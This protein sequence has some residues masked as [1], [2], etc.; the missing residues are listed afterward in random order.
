LEPLRA[1]EIKEENE[2]INKE[3]R[4]EEERERKNRTQLQP[5]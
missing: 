1:K 5:T 3:K 4:R 2:K